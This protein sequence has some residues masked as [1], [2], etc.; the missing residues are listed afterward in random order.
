MNRLYGPWA[1]LIT[2]GQNPQLGAFLRRRM[3]A[4]SR[5]IPTPKACNSIAQ[6][7]AA[8]PGWTNGQCHF[9][10]RS[11]ATPCCTALRCD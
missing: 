8:H 4:I 7:R 6:G 10:P 2:A 5:T 11:G 9:A 3:A 1:T